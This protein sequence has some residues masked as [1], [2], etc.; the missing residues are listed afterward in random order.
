[1]TL[2]SAAR[3]IGLWRQLVESEGRFAGPKFRYILASQNDPLRER[4]TFIVYSR[5]VRGN[6]AFNAGS[7]SAHRR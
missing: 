4:I 1:V 6:S 7:H 5:Y 2:G 3:V